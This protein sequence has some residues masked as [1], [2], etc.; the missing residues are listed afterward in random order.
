MSRDCSNGRTAYKLSS[1]RADALD[2]PLSEG[3]TDLFLEL[4]HLFYMIPLYCIML[5]PSIGICLPRIQYAY[6]L[7][8]VVACTYARL[9]VLL[10]ESEFFVNLSDG[11]SSVG[12][13][14]ITDSL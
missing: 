7:V 9:L 12:G 6:T 11:G 1:G 3:W 14:L 5:Y 13:E 8:S 4:V 2:S 10:G